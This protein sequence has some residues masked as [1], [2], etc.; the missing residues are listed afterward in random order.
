MRTGSAA[1]QAGYT[2]FGL[3]LAI[4]VAS[5]T[6]SAGASLLGNE[7]RRDKERELMFTGDA[8]RRAI[9][10]YHLKNQGSPEPF[11]KRLE[12]LLRDSNQA[13]VQRYLRKIYHD[14]MHEPDLIG[15]QAMSGS[16]I[17]IHD[18]NG[19]IVGV[20]SNSQREPLR[21]DGFPADYVAFRQARSYA[22]WKFVAVGGAP[23]AQGA[24]GSG[25]M[26]GAR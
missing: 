18:A 23:V 3:L 9:E 5:L 20:H 1:A 14:P 17:L 26:E 4:T 16:W 24:S 25:S 13:T 7:V 2:Y 19:Q 6:L 10:Q 15:S 12:S 22:D 8:I 21:K 11:P